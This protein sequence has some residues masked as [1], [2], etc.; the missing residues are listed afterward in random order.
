MRPIIAEGRVRLQSGPKA[1]GEERLPFSFAWRSL[2]DADA[3]IG[4][5]AVT[6]QLAFSLIP[7]GIHDCW[8]NRRKS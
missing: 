3:Q 2:L 5:S 1:V 8:V 7:F 6:G 4:F